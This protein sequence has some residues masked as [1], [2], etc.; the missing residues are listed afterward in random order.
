MWMGTGW[1][2]S[3][4]LFHMFSLL[5]LDPNITST[6]LKTSKNSNSSVHFVHQIHLFLGVFLVLSVSQQEAALRWRWSARPTRLPSTGAQRSNC[7]GATARPDGRERWRCCLGGQRDLFVETRDWLKHETY[8]FSIMI[9]IAQYVA[10][11]LVIFL[12][13]LESHQ[14]HEITKLCMAIR[15]SVPGM[16]K[17]GAQ[18]PTSFESHGTLS[19]QEENHLR[20]QKKF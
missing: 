5:M 6:S 13:M 20:Q 4:L 19:T 8:R 7:T 2:M 9:H 15:W 3:P 14:R 10:S 11:T 17:W 12:S 16:V 18:H 1:Y